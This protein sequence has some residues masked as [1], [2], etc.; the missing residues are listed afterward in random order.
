[1]STLTTIWPFAGSWLVDTLALAY[2]NQPESKRVKWLAF[3]IH[4]GA[5][6]AR[7]VIHHGWQLVP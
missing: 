2:L 6:V 7:V 3:Q 4:V 1:M 5:P